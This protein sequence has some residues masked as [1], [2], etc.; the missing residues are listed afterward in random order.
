MKKRLNLPLS[1]NDVRSLRAGDQILLSGELLTG[2][3]VA[4]KRLCAL[5]EAGEQLPC[6]L[7]GEAI[8]Y[9][10]PTPA[11]PG[12]VVG[13]AGPTTS[14]RMDKYAPR[15]IEQGLRAMIGKGSRSSAVVEAMKRYG[16]VYFAA[17][18]GAG[19]LLAQRITA[20]DVLAWDELGCE[21]LRRIRVD[22]FPV[23]VAIDAEG[24]SLYEEGPAEWC[25]DPGGSHSENC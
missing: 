13:S 2:R 17:I 7:A 11:S 18:G 16:C 23:I 5:L 8:Y 10:G 21:A 3:D 9:V 14:A 22:D 25:S 24:H 15:L 19:A 1:A 20:L 12:H 6:T 4:H